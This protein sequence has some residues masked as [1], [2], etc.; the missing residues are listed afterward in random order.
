MATASTITLEEY[1]STSFEPDVEYVRG[2][3][4]ERKM[5]EYEHNVVQR[6]LLL[7]FFQHDKE[8]S[9][10]TIQEQ[11]IRL[12]SGNVRLPDVSVFRRD[13]PIETVF[14]KPPL[15]AIEVLSPEDTHSRMQ[16][17]IDDYIGFGIQHVWVVDPIRRSGWDCSDGDWTRRERFDLPT[18][19]I[20]L[21][22]PELFRDLDI[23]ES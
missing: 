4:E 20:H 10:R 6:A 22:L 12:N 3:L 21:V 19:P 17:R 16:E 7:W 8:W 9:T 5:G 18:T 23:A 13:T 15:I 2:A 14:T 11:R 1:L